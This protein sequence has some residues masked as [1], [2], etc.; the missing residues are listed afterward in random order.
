MIFD[1][2]LSEL[3][4]ELPLTAKY[5]QILNSKVQKLFFLCIFKNIYIY[6]S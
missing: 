2:W 6:I 5:I 3:L 1:Y 4:S